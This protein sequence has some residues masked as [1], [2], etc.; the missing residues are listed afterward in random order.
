MRGLIAVCV[1]V[2]LLGAAPAS[3]SR[4]IGMVERGASGFYKA[5]ECFS[6]HDHGLPM[7]AFRVARE[8]GVALNEAA[9]NPGF[10]QRTTPEDV[11]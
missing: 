2:P 1:F 5:Q 11:P 4:A 8:H 6:C 3:A 7:L 9:I 10:H